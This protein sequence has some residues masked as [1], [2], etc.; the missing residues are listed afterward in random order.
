[1]VQV[2]WALRSDEIRSTARKVTH[3]IIEGLWTLVEVMIL[4]QSRVDNRQMHEPLRKTCIR[5]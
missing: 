5:R 4:V 3:Q 2:F 1:M